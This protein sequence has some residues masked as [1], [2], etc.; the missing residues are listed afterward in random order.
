MSFAMATFLV[1][2]SARHSPNQESSASSK[3]KVCPICTLKFDSDAYNSHLKSVHQVDL[4]LEDVKEERGEEPENLTCY[5]CLERFED[6]ESLFIHKRG[7][8]ADN[9]GAV[10][11]CTV[12][13]ASSF[14][15]AICLEAHMQ[16]HHKLSWNFECDAC[17]AK[18]P[19]EILL[20]SHIMSHGLPAPAISSV[21]RWAQLNMFMSCCYLDYYFIFYY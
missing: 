17:N 8:L 11:S 16:T 15:N 13:E 5:L 10:A 4:G 21:N 12:C 2:H 3:L 9:Y 14:V 1:K 7:H 18:F 19:E 20:K 6:Q